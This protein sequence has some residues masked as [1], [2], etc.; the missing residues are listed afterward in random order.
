M[1]KTNDERYNDA[2]QIK[3]IMSLWEE[4]YDD[5]N[6]ISILLKL[7][8]TTEWLWFKSDEQF[9][10]Y[11]KI[12]VLENSISEYTNYSYQTFNNYLR[13]LDHSCITQEK[14]ITQVNGIQLICAITRTL[15]NKSLVFRY[16]GYNDIKKNIVNGILIQKGYTSVLY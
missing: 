6:Y 10:L 5:T 16:V 15:S 8:P 14:I 11:D 12:K 4:T 1:R 2:D 7:S 13:K 3:N 9:Y